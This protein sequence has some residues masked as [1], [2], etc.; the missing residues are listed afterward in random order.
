VNEFGERFKLNIYMKTNGFLDGHR[1]PGDIETA[2]YRIVQ[3]ALTNT[4]RYASAT[5]VDVILELRDGK[6][7]VVVED[8]G[9]GFN[10]DMVPEE[11][12]LGL[13][14]MEERAH[15]AGGSLQ[16][17]SKPGQGTTIVVEVPY[18]DSDL[19]R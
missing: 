16:I 3:E 10:T 6:A 5:S 2:L 9:V 1:L 4:I 13:L 14:G 7:V 19:N 11:G 15:M 8:N 18:V 17:E 12:H